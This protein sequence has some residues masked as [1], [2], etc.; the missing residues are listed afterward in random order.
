MAPRVED[1]YLR[2]ATAT[3]GDAPDAT[4]LK[5]IDSGLSSAVSVPTHTATGYC[6]QAVVNTHTSH[7]VG[8]GGTVTPDNGA[9]P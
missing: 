9:C 3:T 7:V 4:G 6:I 1:Q 5:G 2:D 8:P